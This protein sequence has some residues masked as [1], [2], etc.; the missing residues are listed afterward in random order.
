MQSALKDMGFYAA[1]IDGKFGP[2]SRAALTAFQKTLPEIP[3]LEYGVLTG[4][5]TRFWLAK[6]A[7]EKP[8][9][10]DREGIA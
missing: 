8:G 2:L 9:V 5:I 10:P 7:A 1:S 6:T 4:A 3:Q